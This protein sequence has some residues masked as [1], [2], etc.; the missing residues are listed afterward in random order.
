MSLKNLLE[1]SFG[2]VML[3][4]FYRPCDFAVKRLELTGG[5]AFGGGVL[6][7]CRALL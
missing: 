7:H 5:G 3:E 2:G 4:A 6:R 1:R